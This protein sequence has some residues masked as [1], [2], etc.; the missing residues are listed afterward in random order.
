MV[1]MPVALAKDPRQALGLLPQLV[2]LC[3]KAL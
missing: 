3:E 1:E 2:T